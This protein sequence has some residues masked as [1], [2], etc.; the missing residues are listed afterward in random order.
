MSEPRCPFCEPDQER[1]F[2]RGRLVVGLWDAFPVSDGHALLVPKRHVTAWFD[3]TPEE[4]SE[5]TQAIAEARRAIEAVHSPDGYN[6]GVNVGQAAGQTVFHLHVHVIP[7]YAGDVPNPRGGVRHVLPGKGNYRTGSDGIQALARV[8]HQR[9]L[10]RGLGDPFFPHL[11]GH[12]AQANAV[13][14]AVAFTLD[15]G[16]KQLEPHLQ[17]VL[18]RGGRL[19]YLTGDYLGST[20]PSA[21]HALLDIGAANPG[22]AVLRVFQTAA[23][24]T[25]HP[26]AYIV[27]YADGDGVAFVG[28]SNVSRAAFGDNAEWNYRVVSSSDGAAYGDVQTAFEDLFNHSAT[29]PLT[30]AWI[31][32]YTR[33]RT[34]AVWHPVAE[35][36]TEETPELAELVDPHSI[37]VKA[38]AALDATREAGNT[39][40][41][42]VLATGLGK[43]WLAA[44]DSRKSDFKRVLFVAHREEILSQAMHTFRR[45]RP[46]A[47]FGLY[48][49]QE[50]QPDADVLFA[51]IQTLGR[52]HHLEQFRADAFDYIVVDEFHHAAA[53][54]YRRLIDYFTPR[55]LLGLTA[56]PERT[57]GGDLLGLCQENL[58]FRSDLIEGIRADLLCPFH[59]FGVPDEVDY[60]HIPWRSTRFDEEAL[61]DA[62]ATKSRAQNALEQLQKRGGKRTL[63]FCVSQRHADFMARYFSEKGLRA[64]SV[65]S[66]V[67]SSPRT[68]SMEQLQAGELDVV[69]SV[70][71][72]NEGVDLPSLDTVMMLRP[73]ESRIIWLQQFGR[74]LRKAPGKEHLNVIDYIGNH[75]TFL[76]KP[77]TLL[78]LGPVKQDVLNALERLQS[79]EYELPAGCA[80]TFD[81][82][83]IDILKAL[84]GVR[85]PGLLEQ[86]YPE[87]EE[88]HGV[89]PSATEMLHE[90]YDPRSAR[91]RYGSWLGFVQS[92]GGLDQ[93]QQL[94]LTEQQVLLDTLEVTPM[95]RSYKM[96]TLLV[97]LNAGELPGQLGIAKLAEGVRRLASRNSRLSKECGDALSDDAALRRLLEA[98]PIAAWVGARG[99]GGVQYFEYKNGVFRTTF[100]IS[101]PAREGLTELV[102]EIADWRLAEY[103]S[104][105]PGQEDGGGEAAI[106]CKVSHSGG[107]PILFLPDRQSHAGI[108]DGWTEIRADHHDYEANFVKVAVNVVRRTGSEENELPGLLRRWFGPDAGLPGTTHRVEFVPRD[109][110]FD[111]APIG[112]REGQLQLWHTYSREEIP[113]LFGFEFSRAVW[114][115]GYVNRS[116]HMFL[117]VT[118][119][120]AG[121][122]EDFQ[123][124][125]RFLSA[126]VFQWQSQN[127]TTQKSTHGQDIR[128]HVEREIA[129]HL[130]VR[131]GKKSPDG[132]SA[133]FIYC[134]DVEYQSWEGESPIA[135]RWRLREEL[136]QRLRQSLGVVAPH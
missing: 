74:G 54:T 67:S 32:D 39:A 83:A 84:V 25:F 130:F 44:F 28:S 42:V 97:L 93:G 10:V 129:V 103:L 15:R 61:T 99:T 8:P 132:R 133:P 88:L 82:E 40:G 89:R 23:G 123:Y 4:Q 3:A 59:Y 125:D 115:V 70:D 136:P 53:R 124:E 19:R 100:E 47:S 46:E 41:L 101:E 85:G 1:V 58:V 62:V 113:P 91:P 90:G 87:F 126:G 63:A 34:P 135:V 72:F 22:R 68:A 17:D 75:R 119:N 31:A 73:T 108:P 56:T 57:D 9:A 107:R 86:R 79:G 27:R 2:Y 69:C 55:F 29:T 49:G 110:A 26:K 13:D 6:I 48:T 18:D 116:G 92:K 60:S 36:V 111:L 76:L 21:L 5:L 94:A 14:I 78:G 11:T 134:G 112:R 12:L 120:K 128:L 45:I 43:T 64:V 96:L 106:V 24:S 127:R 117:L 65:H 102:R 20:E 98:N 37:Q 121:H 52:V 77:Q 71:M 80:I 50:R 35:H 7:R 30:N 104:R 109:G 38:L 131:R 16:L 122:T 114:N 95:V 118:L 33:R 66:G 81:L 105:P 51:S